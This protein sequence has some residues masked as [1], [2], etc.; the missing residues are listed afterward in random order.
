[1]VN[2]YIKKQNDDYHMI[3]LVDEVGQYVGDSSNRMLNLQSIVEDLGTYTH[4]KAWV[5]VTSQQ[6]IDEV[7][8]NLR[9][10]DFSK[11]SGTFQDTYCH[12][13]S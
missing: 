2:D 8:D 9:G 3:F 13:I 5:I 6:A 4:G 7:T 12:V 10:Q 1:M 11:D